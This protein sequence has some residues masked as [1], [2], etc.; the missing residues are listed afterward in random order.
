MDFKD[1]YSI[2]GVSKDADEKTIKK[3]YQK[4]AKKYHPDVNPGNKEAEEKFKEV[5]EAYEAIGDHEKR[6]KY[7]EVRQ[8]YEAW[9]NNGRQGNYDWGRWQANP[10]QGTYTHT[11]SPEEFAEMFGDF[12]MGG[13]FSGPGGGFSDF[14]STLFGMD[15]IGQSTRR[16]RHAG[17]SQA[18]PQT[19]Q[20][21]EL[22]VSITLEE[23]Y[24]G[25]IRVIKTGVNVS[26][27]E[28]LRGYEQAPKWAREP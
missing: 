12:G 15:D 11:M 13:T 21:R 19:G 3:A 10:G 7:D 4:L 5:A 25:T 18:P 16:G 1:Y 14:F 27:R 8:N 17:Y 9:Q 22:E 26:K 24:H 6:H 28:F 2:L 20:D 23:A